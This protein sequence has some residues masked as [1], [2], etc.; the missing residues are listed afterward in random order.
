MFKSLLECLGFH[1]VGV[2]G[3]SMVERINVLLDA[4]GV[5]MHQ[6]VHSGL[7][8][9]VVPEVVHGLE[10]PTRVDV[11]QGKGRRTRIESFSS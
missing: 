8:R 6:Q 4:L 7:A 1:D 3:G 2:K 5:D 10:F 9:H 11:Q